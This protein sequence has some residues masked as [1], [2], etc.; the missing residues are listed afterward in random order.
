MAD[1]YAAGDI[2]SFPIKQGGIACQ[3]ADAAAAHIAA[4]AGA[5]VEPEPFKP[6]LRGMLLTE[7]S[8]H[9][10]HRET[11]GDRQVAGERCGRRRRRSPA[12]SSPRTWRGSTSSALTD[13]SEMV[14]ALLQ[15]VLA[16]AAE[17]TG[18]RYAALGI[19]DADR[20]QLE[21]FITHGIPDD[22]HRAIGD[23]PRGRGLLGAVIADPRP[24]R[25][26]SLSTDPEA[27]GFPAG[28]PP[29][30]T[31]L[32]VPI[33]IRGE[34]WGNLYL[35]E[36]AGGEPF[37]DADERAVVV[38]AEWAAIAIENAR[39]Y[40]GSEERRSEL[41]RVVRRLEATTA[42]ARALGGETDLARILDLIVERG[43]VLIDA[44]GML[45]LLREA[46][47]L[48]VAA[49]A[50]DVPARLQGTQLGAGPDGVRDALGLAG[51]SLL[52]PLVFRG[53]SLGM[54]AALGARGDD[55]TSSCCRP[56]PRAPR[57]PWRRR[58]PSRN[59]ACATPCAP[60]RPSGGAGRASSTTTRCRGSARCGCCST[61]RPAPAIRSGC[62]RRWRIPSAGS[63][64]RSTTCAG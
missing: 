10:M 64:R 28:H 15:R 53:Q 13:V 9:Y 21:R 16:T 55:G 56:S 7:R 59:S 54:L 36:K 49:G 29:M 1:V 30:E 46:G 20:E 32:G 34:A 6:V 35:S 18:A 2:T 41:E 43:R 33:L 62:G 37:T 63:R 58:A 3:Q 61:R 27:Y 38:L 57:P 5:A 52:V 48:V 24:R 60:P 45:I 23:P 22:V 31:F 50:G 26:E 42:I 19:L 4:R 40:Q 8:A 47:G 25:T 51:D 14:E 17:V 11:V 39:L 12:A 44:R